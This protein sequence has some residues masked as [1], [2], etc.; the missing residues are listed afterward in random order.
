MTSLFISY[1]TLWGKHLF[2]KL[3]YFV[4][5]SYARDKAVYCCWISV[6]ALIND[7]ILFIFLHLVVPLGSVCGMLGYHGTPVGNVNIQ[8]NV[9]FFFYQQ[10]LILLWEWKI[11]EAGHTERLIGMQGKWINLATWHVLEFTNVSMLY[12]VVQIWPG[13]IFFFINTNYENTYLHMSVFNVF[14]SGANTIFP[15][16][17]KHPDALFKKG[18]WLA[19]YPPQTVWMTA[20]SANRALC[21]LGS[22]YTTQTHSYVRDTLLHT[23][24]GVCGEFQSTGRFQRWIWWQCVV[25]CSVLFAL[26]SSN[27]QTGLN[28]F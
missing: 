14:L 16:F 15:M 4:I 28:R 20:S 26:H 24:I 12:K 3:V 8:T 7:V 1:G 5:I 27:S 6:C 10:S 11:S 13:L 18:L 25:P 9:V 2:F 17:W 19:A 21:S 23:V 22:T